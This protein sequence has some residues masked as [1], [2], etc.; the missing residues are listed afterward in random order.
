MGGMGSLRALGFAR[1]LAEA[2]NSVTVVAPRTG[3]YGLDPS[4]SPSEKCRVVRTRSLEPSI[5]LGRGGRAGAP[6]GGPAASK[7]V[8]AGFKGKLR[9]VVQKML[10]VPDPNV[11][12][13]PP[14][15]FAGLREGRARKPDVVLSSSPPFSCH[16][17]AS[18]IARRLGV[19]H[20]ADFRDLFESQRLFGGL[21][22]KID[23]RIEGRVLR[24]MAGFVAAHRGAFDVV[25]ARVPVRG[26]ILENGYDEEDFAAPAPEPLSPFTFVHIGTTYSARRDPRPFF[27]AMSGLIRE[28]REFKVR[29]V[30]APDPDLER[31]AAEEGVTDRCEFAGFTTHRAAVAEMRRASALLLFLWAEDGHVAE[32]TIPGKTLEYLRAGPPILY[33][34]PQGGVTPDLLR[35]LGGTLFTASD[36]EDEVGK[37]LRA[38]LLGNGPEPADP[39]RLEGYSR[40]ASA[41]RLATWLREIVG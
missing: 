33:L 21:R 24:R 37:S 5:L 26:L 18:L 1:H 23:D 20:V 39:G 3:T 14:A 36:D 19:P 31:V 41:A 6:S 16:M 11:G 13:V 40:R 15:F 38:L 10:Y 7:S 35:E 25:S 32:G 2:G 28:G 12:W 34:G 30:G 8:S 9:R 29:F 27:K 22:E 17:A 4:L